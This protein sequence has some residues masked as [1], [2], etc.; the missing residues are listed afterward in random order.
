MAATEARGGVGSNALTAKKLLHSC[1]MERGIDSR[2]A[3]YNA[4][5]NFQ[6]GVLPKAA[7]WKG[8]KVIAQSHHDNDWEKA[9]IGFIWDNPFKTP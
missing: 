7:L 5:P 2:L 9:A 6:R 3:K 8:N 1:A 4:L